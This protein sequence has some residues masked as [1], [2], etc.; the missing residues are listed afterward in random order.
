MIEMLFINRGIDFRKS[1]KEIGGL[2]ALIE[3]PFMALTASAPPSVE[4][5]II[6]SLHLVE[7][8]IVSHDLNR[9]NIFISASVIK[10][11]NV[12][13]YRIRVGVEP[14]SKS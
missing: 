8:V 3:A 13:K 7:P 10:S 4:S 1:F 2:R 5:E 11:L 14:L 12:R 9:R 6:S